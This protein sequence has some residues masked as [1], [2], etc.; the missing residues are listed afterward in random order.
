MTRLMTVN[1]V[2]ERYQVKVKK[3]REMMLEMKC[4]NL[5]SEKCKH[6]RVTEANLLKWE[7][8]RSK[9][10]TMPAGIPG[11]KTRA[12]PIQINEYMNADGTCKRR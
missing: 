4:I 7:E 9:V 5:G 6:L 10:R 3:A 1:D 11:R 12:K 2:A 8:E